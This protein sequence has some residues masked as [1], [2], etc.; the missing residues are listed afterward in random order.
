VH[1]GEAEAETTLIECGEG[2]RTNREVGERA[3]LGGLERM[4]LGSDGLVFRLLHGIVDLVL[5]KL[6]LLVGRVVGHVVE[7]HVLV[8]HDMPRLVSENSQSRGS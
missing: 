5:L 3:E 7:A 8:G 4:G 6:K 1:R 2:P